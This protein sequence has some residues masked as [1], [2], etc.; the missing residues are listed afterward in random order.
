MSV[1]F[2][3]VTLTTAASVSMVIEFVDDGE[4]FPA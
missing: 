3:D 2:M 4:I 1:A